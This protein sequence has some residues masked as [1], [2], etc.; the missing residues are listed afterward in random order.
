MWTKLFRKNQVISIEASNQT[1]FKVK[2]EK[3]KKLIMSTGRILS[4]IFIGYVCLYPN[5]LVKSRIRQNVEYL[6]QEEGRRLYFCGK[7]LFSTFF[8]V[9]FPTLIIANN[10]A[11]ARAIIRDITESET[12]QAISNSLSKWS[13]QN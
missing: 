5:F 6:N 3:A 8:Y 4:I 7:V 1:H 9:F 13:T 11:M 2:L 12:L 10:S